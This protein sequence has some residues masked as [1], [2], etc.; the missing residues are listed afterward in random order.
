M[1]RN[2]RAIQ[3]CIAEDYI[4]RLLPPLSSRLH[5]ACTDLRGGDAVC[6]TRVSEGNTNAAQKVLHRSEHLYCRVSASKRLGW[7]WYGGSSV[8]QLMQVERRTSNAVTNAA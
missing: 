6:S 1:P 2:V 3:G 8:A 7:C 5:T 4:S